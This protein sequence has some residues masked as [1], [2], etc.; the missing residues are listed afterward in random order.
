MDEDLA[1]TIQQFASMLGEGNPPE[2]L[3]P[4][5]DMVSQFASG[6]QS[7]GSQD[8]PRNTQNSGI[9]LDDT[10]SMVFKVKQVMDSANISNDPRNNLLLALKPYLNS[11]RQSK[12]DKCMQFLTLSK[13]F[14]AMK[15]IEE[16]DKK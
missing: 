11:K 2:N 8:Q 10:L 14:T 4:L 12:V 13:L 9:N 15:D 3:S 16:D 6:M 1:K 7:N 5:I